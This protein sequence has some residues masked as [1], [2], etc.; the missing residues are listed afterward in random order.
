MDTFQVPP[1]TD[2]LADVFSED[3]CPG[4][5]RRFKHTAINTFQRAVLG[6][7]DAHDAGLRDV[8]VENKNQSEA[9]D[10]N[11]VSREFH[12]FQRFS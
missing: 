3:T 2:I 5:L 6:A 9:D 4:T 10:K 12:H 7:V 8:I 11:D 1:E